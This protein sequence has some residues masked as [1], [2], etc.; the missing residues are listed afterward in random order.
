MATGKSPAGGGGALVK[1]VIMT[2]SGDV[3]LPCGKPP[4]WLGSCRLETGT[5]QPGVCS[6]EP[7]R[8]GPLRGLGSS[9]GRSPELL[10][11]VLAFVHVSI[12][13]G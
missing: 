6:L 4:G 2:K 9:S 7:P 3:G 8:A 5:P 10:G 11:T 13:Q 12:R 1:G